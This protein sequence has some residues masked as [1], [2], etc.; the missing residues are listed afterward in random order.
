MVSVV[1][2]PRL[3]IAVIIGSTSEGRFC[4]TLAGWFVTQ[5][6]GRSDMTIDVLDLAAT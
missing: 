1:A 2:P 5:A 4:P 6:R 3:T